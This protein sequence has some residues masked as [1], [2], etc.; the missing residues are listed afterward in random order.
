[1]KV[2]VSTT[3][4]GVAKW[5]DDFITH[6]DAPAPAE[7]PA[8]VQAQM[9]AVADFKE[10]ATSEKY[11]NPSKFMGIDSGQ[12]AKKQ[13]FIEK[14]TN[15]PCGSAEYKL[16]KNNN[17]EG[18][19]T[20]PDWLMTLGEGDM[21]FDHSCRLVETALNFHSSFQVEDVEK[22]ANKFSEL[23]SHSLNMGDLT[24][25]NTVQFEAFSEAFHKI[26]KKIEALK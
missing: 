4:G 12:D 21:Y 25:V 16:Y 26:M 5:P 22:L 14:I 8:S 7:Y 19:P 18:F 13:F 24:D 9:Q 2:N 17:S 20:H 10:K 15:N 11:K 1:M 23:E 6:P 3:A